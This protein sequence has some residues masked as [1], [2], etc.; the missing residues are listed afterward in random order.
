MSFC[1]GRIRFCIGYEAVAA[2]TAILLIDRQNRVIGCILAAAL[3]EAGHVIAMIF[4]RV[5]VRG[6]RIRLFDILI[7]ADEA[8]TLS[9]DILVTLGG[10]GMNLLLAA[11]FARIAPFFSAA[12]LAMGLFNLM[13]VISLDG[14]RILSLL[15]AKRW[16][17]ENAQRVLRITSFVILLPLMTAGILFL[18]RSGY[19]YSLLA[20]SLY[21]LAVLLL[22]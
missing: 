10:P 15:A 18:F 2:V 3:H 19:N 7:E 22:K 9:A 13:P 20:V 6:V 4:C 12:N 14:G 16:G 8:A 5:R 21:L 1:I 11:S 17:V